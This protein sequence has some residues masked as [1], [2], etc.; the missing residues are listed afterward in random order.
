[1]IKIGGASY[2]MKI[3]LD[4]IK[5]TTNMSVEEHSFCQSTQPSFSL[6]NEL[7]LVL[8]QYLM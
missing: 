3:N 2:N 8:F 4:I 1:M 7:F 6:T 5:K